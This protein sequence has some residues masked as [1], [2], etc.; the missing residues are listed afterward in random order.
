MWHLQ[1]FASKLFINSIQQTQRQSKTPERFKDDKN[2]ARAL[3]HS[4]YS[5]KGLSEPSTQPKML[6]LHVQTQNRKRSRGWVDGRGGVGE[7]GTRRIAWQRGSGHGTQ[8]SSSANRACLTTP[9]VKSS[10]EISLQPAH[11]QHASC[12]L[13][14]SL[15][16]SPFLSCSLLSLHPCSST[17]LF[18]NL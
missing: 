6:H 17:V 3:H 5:L 4:S 1:V 7:V 2:S 18:L 8:E 12:P 15:S 11:T 16:L 13:Q 14:L 10:T 9:S